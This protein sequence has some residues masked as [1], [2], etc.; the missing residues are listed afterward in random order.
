M[1]FL[2]DHVA[3]LTAFRTQLINQAINVL[4]GVV[5]SEWNFEFTDLAGQRY[6]LTEV[7]VQYWQNELIYREK[8]YYNKVNRIESLKSA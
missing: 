6:S 2:K 4:T 5:F 7:S 8:F 3:V 1:N